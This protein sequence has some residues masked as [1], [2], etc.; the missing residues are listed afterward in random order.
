M[1]SL[2][3]KKGERGLKGLATATHG[4]ANP[5]AIHD[6]GGANSIAVPKPVGVC[7]IVFFY[8]RVSSDC[9][10][11]PIVSSQPTINNSQLLGLLIASQ[12]LIR[13]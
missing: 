11:E 9:K 1:G 3:E 7:L 12:Q 2:S 6:A 10:M 8:V 13:Q 5:I 4:A